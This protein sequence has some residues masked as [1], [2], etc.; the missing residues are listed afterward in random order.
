MEMLPLRSK[1][2]ERAG[3]S[4]TTGTD[5]ASHLTTSYPLLCRRDLG[6]QLSV[7]LR[8]TA[9]PW[10]H[11]VLA[12]AR[13]ETN[14]ARQWLQWAEGLM[15]RAMYDRASLFTRATKE[16]DHDFAAFG[17]A[18]I[19]VTLNRHANA[20]LYR[21]WH[22]RDVAWQENAEGKVCPIYRRWKPQARVLRDIFPGKTHPDVGLAA[23]K[24]PF[25]EI[26][27]GHMLLE[28]EA[29]DEDAKGRPYWSVYY[30]VRHNQVIEAV[31]V[32]NKG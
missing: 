11:T 19:Q 14:Q 9:K 15:R 31:P 22:L 32:W 21:S 16:G 26:E 12:D 25:E 2:I 23:E 13:R 1:R 28:A 8:P 4:R 20:L 6:D 27:C 17:Q 7:M 3:V 29:Y 10:F 5:F 24:R 30:D 18:C